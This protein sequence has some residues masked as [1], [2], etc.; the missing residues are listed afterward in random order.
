MPLTD[1]SELNL[2]KFMREPTNGELKIMLDHLSKQMD[3]IS[4]DMKEVKRYSDRITKLE[5]WK[6]Y[7]GIAIGL[8]WVLSPFVWLF[9]KDQIQKAVNQSVSTA[10]GQYDIIVHDN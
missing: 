7:L 5:D 3:G 10:F 9:I 2:D 1:L 6:L 4:D 8:M